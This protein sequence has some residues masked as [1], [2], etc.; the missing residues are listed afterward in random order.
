M[1]AVWYDRQGPAPQVLQH[2]ELPTPQPGPGEVRVRLYASAVNPADANR[3]AGRMHT[4]EFPRI[5][6]HSDG[7]GMIDA[8][9]PGIDSNMVGARVWICFGQRGRPFGTAA[10]YICLPLELTQ[11]LPE[12]IA[13]TQGA[14]LGIPGLTAYC[15]L[16]LAGPIA[17][18]TVLVT[19]AAG[20]VG[21]Y[22]VQLAKWAGA[23]V[24]ATVSSPE[25]K[26]HA[27][28][29]GA[30]AVIDYT[31][32]DA[33]ARIFEAT[34]GK[35]VEHI[36]DVDAIGNLALCLEVAANHAHW[37]SYAVG[38]DSSHAL[39]LA[40]LIRKNISLR[41]L[42]MPD[43]AP[44]LRRE[45]QQG[46]T[47]WLAEVPDAV[48]AVHKVFPLRETALAHAEVE[49]RSKLGTVVVSCE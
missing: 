35:G 11:P 13:F 44:S 9:G 26:A 34:A 8:V 3:R 19:G 41:G 33:A 23:R 31:M 22:T 7:A 17:G 49:A 25:K 6:P 48:H 32:P 37:I 2:G 1:M 16:F 10:Q 47:R 29:G 46:L 36:V 14:C 42:Y 28:R 38:P 24:I 15:S 30:D 45:A 4:M 5:V 40:R 20:A 12:A 43:I 27:E 39:P 18:K 21:H